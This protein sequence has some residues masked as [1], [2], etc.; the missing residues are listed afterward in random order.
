MS[1]AT[2]THRMLK[3]STYMQSMPNDNQDSLIICHILSQRQGGHTMSESQSISSEAG[4][5]QA[6]D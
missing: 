3:C 6:P 4:D 2:L 1:N 5:L